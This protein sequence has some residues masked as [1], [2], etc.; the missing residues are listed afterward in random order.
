M[1]GWRHIA[2]KVGTGRGSNSPACI[3]QGVFAGCRPHKTHNPA[4]RP[5]TDLFAGLRFVGRFVKLSDDTANT[6]KKA[7]K[8]KTPEEKFTAEFNADEKVQDEFGGAEGLPN[9]ISFRK[10][11]EK[12]L[13]KLQNR[14]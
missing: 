13:V 4:E 7:E 5:E 12:G 8:P 2:Q 11:Q 14:G 10:A 1:L 9:Y 6:T 3:R